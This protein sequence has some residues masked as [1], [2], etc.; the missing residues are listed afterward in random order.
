MD[1]RSAARFAGNANNGNCSSRYLNANNAV[2]NANR[3]NAG[4]AQTYVLKIGLYLSFMPGSGE[5]VQDKRARFG[6]LSNRGTRRRKPSN[7]PRF[8]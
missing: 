8:E 5:I 7:S 3:N 6:E 4:S 2:S 1:E